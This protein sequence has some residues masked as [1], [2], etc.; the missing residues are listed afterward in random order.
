MQTVAQHYY[1]WVLI[2]VLLLLYSRPVKPAWIVTVDDQVRLCTMSI[3]ILLLHSYLLVLHCNPSHVLSP[4]T[5]LGLLAFHSECHCSCVWVCQRW[6]WAGTWYCG[7]EE[8]DADKNF[9]HHSYKHI[10]EFMLIEVLYQTTIMF[11][12]WLD[13]VNHEQPILMAST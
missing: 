1:F 7:T 12:Q 9:F 13:D 8:V 4:P 11:A 2:V 5:A 10:V 6:W 3:N